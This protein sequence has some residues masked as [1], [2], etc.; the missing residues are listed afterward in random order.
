[1]WFKTSIASIVLILTP[2]T[3]YTI[4]AELNHHHHE[5]GPAYPHMKIMHKRW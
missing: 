3:A 1:M 5:G 4:W 2:F